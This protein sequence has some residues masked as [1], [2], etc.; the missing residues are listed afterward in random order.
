MLNAAVIAVVL[1][2]N[3]AWHASAANDIGIKKTR[4]YVPSIKVEIVRGGKMDLHLYHA[5]S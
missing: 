5:Q 3:V 1:M 4:D 2:P